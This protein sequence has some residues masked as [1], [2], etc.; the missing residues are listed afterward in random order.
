MKK[1]ILQFLKQGLMAAS[2]GPVVLAII[3]GIL[4]A[5]GAVT[6][7]TPHEVCMGVLTVTLMAFIAA[8]VG[9]VYQIEQLPLLTATF[10]HAAAL[11]LDYLLIYLLNDWVPRSALGI[12]IFTAVYVAGYAIIWLII[13]ISIKTRTASINRKLR[14]EWK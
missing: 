11:Y 7:F 1:Y 9:V 3:Y 5:T 14:G 8:G 12:G 13:V 10:L 2:G 4:G 6:S